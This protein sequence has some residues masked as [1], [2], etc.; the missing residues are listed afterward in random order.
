MKFLLLTLMLFSQLAHANY[1]VGRA[2]NGESEKCGVFLYTGQAQRVANHPITRM[3]KILQILENDV[4][5]NFEYQSWYRSYD[6]IVTEFRA[7]NGDVIYHDDSCYD[8]QSSRT[9][10]ACFQYKKCQYTAH[11][12]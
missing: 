3:P 2:L 11:A 5:R 12:L 1:A 8:E 7:D 10:I 4:A 9:I 6:S